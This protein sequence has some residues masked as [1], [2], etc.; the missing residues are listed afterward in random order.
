[1]SSNT[2]CAL[3]PEKDAV[4]I[5]TSKEKDA[6]EMRGRRTS[7]KADGTQFFLFS[8]TTEFVL[9]YYLR[10]LEKATHSKKATLYS[11]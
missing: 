9:L 3:V 8:T 2:S 11:Q 10:P 1:M 4:S 7:K 6:L 5:A